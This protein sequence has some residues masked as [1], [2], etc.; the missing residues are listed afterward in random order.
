[1][2]YF[3]FLILT[4]FAFNLQAATALELTVKAGD[5][6]KNY[7]LDSEK[8]KKDQ[9]DYFYD[10]AKKILKY[11]SQNISFCHRNYIQLQLIENNKTFKM[12]GCLHSKEKITA[13]LTDFA[14]TINLQYGN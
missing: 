13:A 8:T 1:M 3:N 10:K 6:I 2:K 4:L 11:K 9:F 14:N 5:N 12:L 7:H